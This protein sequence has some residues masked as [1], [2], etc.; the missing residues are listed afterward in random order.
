MAG[1]ALPGIVGTFK[2][3]VSMKDIEDIARDAYTLA[4][5]MLKARNQP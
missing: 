2:Q 5:A 3:S 4:D 1:Q